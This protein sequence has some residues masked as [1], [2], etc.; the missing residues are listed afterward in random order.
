MSQYFIGGGGG[1]GTGDVVGPAS[2]TDNAIVRF[3]G[4]TGKLIQNGVSIETDAGEILAGNGSYTNP[5]FSFISDSTVGF[6]GGVDFL[7]IAASNIPIGQFTGTQN[8]GLPTFD[9]IGASALLGSVSINAST[10]ITTNY[11]LQPSDCFLGVTDTSVPLTITLNHT[12]TAYYIGRMIYIKDETGGAATNNITIDGGG[13]LIDGQ[14]TKVINTDYGSLFLIG[15]ADGNFATIADNALPAPAQPLQN[16]GFTWDGNVPATFTVTS[17]NGTALSAGN[18]GWVSMPSNVA[19][20]YIGEVKNYDITADQSFTDTVAG[21]I[22]GM[23][24][25]ATTGVNWDEFCPFYMY[26]VSKSDDSDIAFMISRI[27]GKTISPAAGSIGKAGAIVN[28]GEGDFFSLKNVTVAK[29]AGTSCQCIG[30][31]TMKMDGATD[32]WYVSESGLGYDFGVGVFGENTVYNYP[33]GQNTATSGSH[34]Y[35]AGTLPVFTD[36]VATYSITKDGYLTYSIRYSIQTSDGAGGN[37]VFYTVP[38]KNGIDY[39]SCIGMYRATS[40]TATVLL[41]AFQDAGNI[42]GQLFASGYTDPLYAYDLAP[43]DATGVLVMTIQYKLF[44]V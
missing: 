32:S 22:S 9:F 6:Y 40:T 1:G 43:G 17:A 27:P 20:L 18:K 25:G 36:Q 10:P 26:A 23:L 3:D 16:L 39:F 15:Q 29:Y 19:N 7:G 41:S 35:S 5:A 34:F 21:D 30:A 2:S 14:A 31:F 28:N 42:Q 12:N 38:L 24:F 33:M 44:S 4:T 13:F 8:F 37:P 11:N